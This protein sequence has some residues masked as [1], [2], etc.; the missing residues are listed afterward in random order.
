MAAVRL[1]TMEWRD[2]PLCKLLNEAL[3][4]DRQDELKPWLPYLQLFR[5]GVERLPQFE[6][7]C[8]S[9]SV[10]KHETNQIPSTR[11][12]D[13][14]HETK[15]SS[16]SKHDD[17]QNDVDTSSGD[18]CTLIIRLTDVDCENK[19]SKSIE[20]YQNKSIATLEE[21]L[22]PIKNIIPQ[23]DDYIRRAKKRAHTTS[24]NV[25][26]VD[27]SAAIYLYTM[28]LN[29][30]CFSRMLNRAL[31]CEDQTDLKK[32]WFSYL[33]LICS[34][35]TKLPSVK[36][37]VYQGVTSKTEKK[38]PKN[39]II[40]WWGITSCTQTPDN[41]VSSLSDEKLT[42]LNIKILNGKDIS[43]YSCNSNETE[44]IL[45]PGTRLRVNDVSYNTNFNIDEIDLEEIDDETLQSETIRQKTKHRISKDGSFDKTWLECRFKDREGTTILKPDECEEYLTD[46]SEKIDKRI[47]DR[48]KGS[49]FGLV[50]GDALG[51]HVEF[52]P[53]SYMLANQVTDL[54]GGGTW[55]LEKGQFTDD[56]SM[57]L[58]LANSLV[59][60]RGFEPYDQLVRYKWW[61]RHG[62]MSSTG[63]CFDIGEST[64]KALRTFE[65][66]QKEFAEK[67][68]IPLEEIDF[69]SD[70][71][72]LKDFPMY[73]SS[74]GAA[75]NGVLMRLAPVPLFFYRSPE[76]AVRFSGISG[77]IT[78]GDK[79]A[80]DACRYYGA[81]IVATMGNIDKNKLLSEEYYSSKIK[82]LFRNDPL[83]V[84]IANIAKG[85]FK[86]EKGY[87]AGIRGK[88]YVV[89][90]L[91]AALWAFWSTHSFEEGAR[92][93][94]NLGD[95]TDTTAAIYGQLAGAHY[96]YE[97]LPQEWVN[98][99][100]S[101]RF[102]ECLCKWIAYE[103]SQLD[104]NN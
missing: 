62:Y 81:L 35:L 104:F 30:Q 14:Y 71:Q 74:D 1:Y 92:A 100:Y 46:P 22:N 51:A 79:K 97:K 21:A 102:I 61:F 58:C 43:A 83:D 65:D 70:K 57:A 25:L 76:V 67:Y 96:G 78:H 37:H 5:A 10:S 94:V 66:R 26:T 3:K 23:L 7:E 95:D 68:N 93:A 29:D 101:K 40:T 44:I 53:H 2:E 82:E 64:R 41:I 34:A 56:G 89:N 48:I 9:S 6:G 39:E 13:N 54:R 47:L 24:S 52:R 103:G 72:L 63:N 8:S 49:M 73:C 20:G 32:Y 33:G 28:Q 11:S 38:Y 59:A 36:G 60:R 69:L 90:S 45:L 27:E 84:E 17:N 50:L 16:K 77:E 91:E 31:R 99:V 18:I 42:L 98:C 87:D 80:V 88:G 85:S 12:A 19:A 4:S 55:G 75:G 86:K 15:S